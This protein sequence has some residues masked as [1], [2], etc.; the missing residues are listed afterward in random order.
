[1][2]INFKKIVLFFSNKIMEVTNLL[3]EQNSNLQNINPL[4]LKKS[5][6]ETRNL[7]L[8]KIIKD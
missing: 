6:L 8:K 2:Y 7:E 1:M 5:Q 3:S 4:Q